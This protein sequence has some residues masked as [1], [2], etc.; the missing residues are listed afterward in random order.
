MFYSWF[1]R[2]EDTVNNFIIYHLPFLSTISL[3]TKAMCKS[4]FSK[5][6]AQNW[7]SQID[8]II[9]FCTYVNLNSSRLYCG[10]LISIIIANFISG[11]YVASGA[12][13]GYW[14]MIMP[15][16][17]ISI[18]YCITN[19]ISLAH[20]YEPVAANALTYRARVFNY[21]RLDIFVYQEPSKLVNIS[22][23]N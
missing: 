20:L 11:M 18:V 17:S 9:R 10:E 6:N 16:K 22:N 3:S 12:I 23:L 7:Y 14:S 15:F 13:C 21:M 8:Y 2:V 19:V 5:C 1:Y 4:Y